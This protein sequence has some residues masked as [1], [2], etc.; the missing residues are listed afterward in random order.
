MRLGHPRIHGGD[1]LR[2]TQ[3]ERIRRLRGE[4]APITEVDERAKPDQGYQNNPATQSAKRT[5]SV[6][7]RRII[8]YAQ[9]EAGHRAR[10]DYLRSAGSSNLPRQLRMYTRQ[11]S[12]RDHIVAPE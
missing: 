2:R 9:G 7:T 1:R 4:A 10:L 12:T 11:H 6:L 5:R 8:I 3:L